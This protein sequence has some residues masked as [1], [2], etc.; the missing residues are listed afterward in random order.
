MPHDHPAHRRLA[1]I[2]LRA[3]GAYGFA[4]AG[5][6]AVAAHG[7]LQRPSEDVDLFTD[8]HR[9][10][11]FPAAVDAVVAA[12]AAAGYEVEIEHRTET[13]LGCT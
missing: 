10:A 6:H 2:G 4:L 13:S 11:D 1:E 12:Y 9:R 8:W 3:G 7:I 5:G